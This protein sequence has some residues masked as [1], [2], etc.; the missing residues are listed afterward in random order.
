MNDSTPSS[1][2]TPIEI[3]RHSHDGPAVVV[4]HGGPG[5]PGSAR[6]LAIGLADDF[7]VLE[8]FQRRAAGGRLSV[9][10]HVDDLSAMLDRELLGHRPA[11]VGHSWGA[12]LALAFSAAHPGRV[13]RIA[14]VGCGTFDTR[15]RAELMRIIDLRMTPTVRAGLQALAAASADAD[16]ALGSSGTLLAP[17]Y[18]FDALPPEPSGAICDARGH[19]QTWEDMIRLQ[20]RGTYPAAFGAIRCP[21]L[22]LHG[23]HDPHPGAMIRD[24]LRRRMPQLEYSEIERCGHHPWRERQASEGF[25]EALKEWLRRA[26]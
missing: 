16:Q 26:R 9:K 5:A 21:V 24:T 3:R 18:D 22:M 2:P 7:M 19:R 20:K 8:P 25:F 4:L 14:L 10:H 17:L 13:S 1:G 11:L 12:M 15:A 6:G 23:A